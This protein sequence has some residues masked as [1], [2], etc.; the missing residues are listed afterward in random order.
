MPLSPYQV[1][2]SRSSSPS[3]IHAIPLTTL[4]ILNSQFRCPRPGPPPA[5]LIGPAYIAESSGWPHRHQTVPYLQGKWKRRWDS[6][7]G[8][9]KSRSNGVF[10]GVC[11]WGV[12]PRFVQCGHV[13]VPP[14]PQDMCVIWKMAPKSST[15]VLSIINFQQ[16]HPVWG[17]HVLITV[18]FVRA[19]QSYSLPNNWEVVVL[20]QCSST[21]R[22]K[23]DTWCSVLFLQKVPR[24]KRERKRLTDLI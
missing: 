6:Y 14:E 23:E 20:L 15:T 1:Q 12:P 2:D 17:C 24:G 9:L 21:A 16:L 4:W 13:S 22:K 3:E 8:I 18:D 10:G 7:A 5:S 11:R 19:K